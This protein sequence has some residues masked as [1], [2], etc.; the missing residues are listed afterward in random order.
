MNHSRV[1][2]PVSPGKAR[3]VD[4]AGL[5]CCGTQNKSGPAGVGTTC[6][7]GPNHL[8]GVAVGKPTRAPHPA[9]IGATI[10][11]PLNRHSETELGD[12][13]GLLALT[14]CPPDDTLVSVYVPLDPR[15][16]GTIA[17]IVGCEV[18]A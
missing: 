14:E 9:P 5:V 16:H 13:R 11:I 17:I 2:P 1:F 7:P 8:E 15:E 4:A 18:R 10:T 6:E 12:L 3:E